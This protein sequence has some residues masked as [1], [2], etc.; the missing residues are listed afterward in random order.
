MPNRETLGKGPCKKIKGLLRV[1]RNKKIFT[2][3]RELNSEMKHM[4]FSY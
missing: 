1:Q 4:L 3:F 2:F